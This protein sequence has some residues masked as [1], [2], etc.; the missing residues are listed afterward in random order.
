MWV[1]SARGCAGWEEDAESV[2]ADPEGSE[3]AGLAEGWLA[4]TAKPGGGFDALL[5]DLPWDCSRWRR[6]ATSCL[7]PSSM[8]RWPLPTADCTV[9]SNAAP[10]GSACTD[11][12]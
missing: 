1:V 6:K 12:S 7:V 2:A 8:L 3:E 5:P 9:R 4:A 11:G 10:S